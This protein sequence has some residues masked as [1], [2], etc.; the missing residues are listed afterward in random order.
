MWVIVSFYATFDGRCLFHFCKV[1]LRSF[2]ED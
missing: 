1:L 2:P